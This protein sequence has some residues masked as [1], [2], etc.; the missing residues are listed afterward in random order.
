MTQG[1][2]AKVGEK[3]EVMG[4]DFDAKRSL[5]EALKVQAGHSGKDGAKVVY[6]R[7]IVG[8]QGPSIASHTSSAS[9]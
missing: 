5:F 4:N 1:S 7:C 8:E 9:V 6:A 3:L 2:A